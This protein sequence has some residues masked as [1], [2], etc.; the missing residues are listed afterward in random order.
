MKKVKTVLVT[1]IPSP[2]RA[3]QFD[4]LSQESLFDLCVIYCARN[5]KNRKWK[6][7]ELHHNSVF[8]SNSTKS[9]GFYFQIRVIR[10]LFKLMPKIIITAGFTPTMLLSFL[11]AKLFNINHVVFTDSWLHSVN[12]MSCIHKVIRKI[13]IKYSNKY[14]CVG[15]KGARF[16]QHYGAPL[17]DIVISPLS[18]DNKYFSEFYGQTKKYDIMFSGQFVERKL[19][20][21]FIEVA[22]KVKEKINNLTV[23]LIGSGP[24]Q[25]LHGHL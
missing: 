20:F 1:N 12:N 13:V 21:F 25:K 23:L 16:L 18:I 8:L 10:F 15:K 3:R 9:S 14:V 2:Y 7:P 4:L 22:K 5:E 24:L 17:K 6:V 11:F 19:P